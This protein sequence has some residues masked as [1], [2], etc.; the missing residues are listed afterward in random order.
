MST[1][2]HK[3]LLNAHVSI[4]MPWVQVSASLNKLFEDSKLQLVCLH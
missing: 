4:Y 1:P 3:L 2:V